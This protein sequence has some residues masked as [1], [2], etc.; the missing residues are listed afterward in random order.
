MGSG[1]SNGG[2]GSWGFQVQEIYHSSSNQTYRLIYSPFGQCFQGKYQT[3]S[4]QYSIIQNI[5]QIKRTKFLIKIFSLSLVVTV[6]KFSH[7][8]L[9]SRF[10][11]LCKGKSNL[12][13]LK[14]CRHFK[15]LLENHFDQKNKH[16]HVVLFQVCSN[17]DPLYLVVQ[18]F[19]RYFVFDTLYLALFLVMKSLVR[20]QFRG[21]VVLPLTFSIYTF[22]MYILDGASRN[23]KALTF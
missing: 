8:H 10:L 7:F 3:C 1:F 23:T 15:I 19:S 12:E 17:H 18:I 6:V 20:I 21:C 2:S 16:R 11:Q 22:K 13:L 5:R 14:I 9:F 4:F